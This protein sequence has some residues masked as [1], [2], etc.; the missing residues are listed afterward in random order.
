MGCHHRYRARSWQLGPLRQAPSEE[1][2]SAAPGPR[3]VCAS[4]C[5][6]PP[7][8]TSPLPPPLCRCFRNGNC[9]ALRELVSWP[10]VPPVLLGLGE[11]APKP[12]LDAVA[13]WTGAEFIEKAFMEMGAI[14]RLG[15]SRGRAGAM[16]IGPGPLGAVSGAFV[17]LRWY[18][19]RRQRAEQPRIPGTPKK[20]IA[21]PGPQEGHPD[22]HHSPPVFVRRIGLPRQG[23]KQEQR[24]WC[25]ALKPSGGWRRRRGH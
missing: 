4:L 20:H 8:R 5:T 13:P 25:R 14:V 24:Q 19:L 15:L 1:G 10:F 7:Q 2:Q 3:G 16:N 18:W 11:M 12:Q 6:R 17:M 21:T 9:P 23:R 22:S